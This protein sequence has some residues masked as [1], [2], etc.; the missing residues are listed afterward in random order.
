M[1]YKGY[2]TTISRDDRALRTPIAFRAVRVYRDADSLLC[3]LIIDENIRVAISII[4]YQIASVRFESHITAIG[5]DGGGF[6]LVV[7]LT[8]VRGNRSTDSNI[9]PLC[10]C[11]YIVY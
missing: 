3:Q 4:I 11:R 1:R 5:G 6:G 9:G 7:T 10:R 8:S 2:I